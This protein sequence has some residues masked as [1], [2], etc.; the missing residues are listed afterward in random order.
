MVQTSIRLQ[1]PSALSL[2]PYGK[3][4]AGRDRYSPA[5]HGPLWSQVSMD[6]TFSR[7]QSLDG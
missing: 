5:H 1:P 4:R 7:S 2:R 6:G 3:T